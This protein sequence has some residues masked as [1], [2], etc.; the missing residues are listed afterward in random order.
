MKR[1]INGTLYNTET[2][3]CVA[4]NEFADGTNRMMCG[5]CTSLYRT[6]KGNF[7]AW[8]ETCWQ[9]E[10]DTIEPLT[11]EEAKDLYECLDGDGDYE[12][13]FG[14]VPEEA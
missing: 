11:K 2:A 4:H 14:E 12:K 10:H 8:H 9:G 3:E 13:I 7:F 6:S 1:V 5:R